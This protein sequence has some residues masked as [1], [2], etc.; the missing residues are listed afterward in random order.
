V[1]S[2]APLGE[3]RKLWSH[4][5]GD[6]EGFLCIATAIR[7]VDDNGVP[8]KKGNNA[9]REFTNEFFHYPEEVDEALAYVH[10]V[11]SV[12]LREVW[13]SK[14]L[15][16]TRR[17]GNDNVVGCGALAVELDGPPLPDGKLKPTAVL[18]SSPAHL[19][20]DGKDHYHTYLAIDPS[21]PI[22]RA[23][24]LNRRLGKKIRGEKTELSGL[25][26]LPCTTNWKHREEP[27]AEL[28]YLDDSRRFD[29]YIL[30]TM[31]PEEEE[32]EYTRPSSVGGGEPPVRLSGYD[33]EV[34]EG[35]HAT[36]DDRSGSLCRLADV[37]WRANLQGAALRDALEERDVALGWEKYSGRPDA[38][39]RYWEI[40]ELVSSGER[41]GQ[42]K[43]DSAYSAYS[44][45][46]TQ[47]EVEWVEP[48]AFHSFDR[49]AFPTGIFP[50]WMEDYVN[51]VALAT[52]T[53]RDLA[54]MLGISVGA[55]AL[56]KK[57]EVEVWDG[58]FE[59][60]IFPPSL[61][62]CSPKLIDGE[63]FS[64]AQV[65]GE[66]RRSVRRVISSS[67]SHPSPTKE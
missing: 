66:E 32:R 47:D 10:K 57:M 30:D 27:V 21:T 40:V 38:D 5:Y 60:L 17:R 67:C 49:P 52:Q 36:G 1:N 46:S 50:S 41:K 4:I 42:E 19:N 33:L 23:S 34:W 18:L 14:T 8:I 2:N 65:R 43:S 56:A 24:E 45:D 12:P 28:L 53:P 59:P 58:W 64:D 9:T 54:G 26:R 7:R 22:D 48:T 35:K 44:A 15:F 55:A 6:L 31:L 11:N 20:D 37:L 25:L 29:E 62:P 39:K 61:P 13:F 51:A 63:V 3:A 16:K